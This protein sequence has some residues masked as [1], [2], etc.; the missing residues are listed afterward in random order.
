MKKYLWLFLPFLLCAYNSHQPE[1]SVCNYVSSGYYQLIYEADI[2]YLSGD[3]EGAYQKIKQAENVCP[4]IE[5]EMY[6][7][8]SNYIELLCERDQFEKAIQYVTLLVRDYGYLPDQFEKED[9]FQ[10]LSAHIDWG[11]LK[12]QLAGLSKAFYNRVDTLLVTELKTMTKNDQIVRK[13]RKED[14]TD[15]EYWQQMR[16][17]D[18]VHETRIKEIFETYGYPDQRLIGRKNTLWWSGI[19]AMLMHFSDTIYFPRILLNYTENGKCSPRIL[20]N[21]VDSNC[22]SKPNKDKFIYG[23][24]SNV[25]DEEIWDS[26]NL[27]KRRL[28]IGMPT[29]QM[30]QL[31]DS[32]IAIKYKLI[33]RESQ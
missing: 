33:T 22:R 19:D 5:Q 11:I 8:I 3:K 18:A 7:E 24:Y 27:D 21:F 2:A 25:S 10:S 28:S 32:L 15:E 30:K 13:E 1:Q 4:L 23:T 17:T 16:A 12:Q 29:R 9:Y 14:L 31:R 26:A 6:Y 20:A